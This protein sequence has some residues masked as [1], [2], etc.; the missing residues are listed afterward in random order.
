YANDM[1]HRSTGDKVRGAELALIV[2]SASEAGLALRLEGTTKTGRAFEG[3]PASGESSEAPGLCG[4][5]FRFLGH[6]HFD[7]KKD[8]FDRFDIGALGEGWGG[9]P[10]QAATTNYYR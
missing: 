10:K 1:A 3:A 6:L 7:A 4:A 2:E 5:D 9:G 8:A